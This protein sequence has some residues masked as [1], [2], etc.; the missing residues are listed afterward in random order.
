MVG[1]GAQRGTRTNNKG[2]PAPRG[3]LVLAY[4]GYLTSEL[5]THSSASRE[6]FRTG[7]SISKFG[8]KACLS[9]KSPAYGWLKE[10][11][12]SRI[13]TGSLSISSLRY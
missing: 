3:V 9:G 1:P 10:L 2:N 7:D 5:T 8:P 13:D 6:D 4:G 11:R 12:S